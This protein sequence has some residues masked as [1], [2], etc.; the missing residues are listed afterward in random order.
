MDGTRECCDEVVAIPPQGP[1]T[2]LNVSVANGILV[3]K[4]TARD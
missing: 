1:I 2:S 3:S 4:L